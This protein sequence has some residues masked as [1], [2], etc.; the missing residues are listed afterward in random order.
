MRKSLPYICILS[1]AMAYDKPPKL[2]DL[3]NKVAAKCENKWELVGIQLDLEPSKLGSF[4]RDS[5]IHCF[6]EVFQLWEKKGDP[7]YTWDTIIDVL[8]ADSIG[9]NSL[10]NDLKKWLKTNPY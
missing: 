2:K 4:K 7:P 1:I 6:K 10:A 9:E 8:N 3:L 5:C